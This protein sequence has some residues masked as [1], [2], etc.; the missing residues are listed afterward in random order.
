[1]ISDRWERQQRSNDCH[2][3]LK[4]A[5][6]S[7]ISVHTGIKVAEKW[8]ELQKEIE[9]KDPRPYYYLAVL[10]YLNALDDYSESLDIAKI[11]HRKAYKIVCD[12]SNVRLVKADRIR[13]ILIEGKGMSRIKSVIDLSDVW[14]QDGDKLIKFKG[15]FQGIG[16]EKN[17][18]IGEIRVTFPNELRNIMVH[19]KMGDKNVI[20][21]NQ[22]THILEFGVG[23]TF[24]R[25]EAI[26]N[27]VKDITRKE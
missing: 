25:L 13:D 24:E 4:V 9:I 18:K 20:S 17:P 26:N 11:N 12:N 6:Q 14:E 3:W 16:D 23:F 19:F 15:K 22:T 7:S 2:R 1:M 10:H 27:T 8:E 21:I 5:K